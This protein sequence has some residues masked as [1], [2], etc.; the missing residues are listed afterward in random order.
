MILFRASDEVLVL[1]KHVLVVQ[2][3][4]LFADGL[5]YGKLVVR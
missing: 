1:P 4:V 2:L 3:G 5:G